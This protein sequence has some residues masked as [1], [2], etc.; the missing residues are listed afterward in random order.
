MM[1]SLLATQFGENIVSCYCELSNYNY[2]LE[3]SLFKVV[4]DTYPVQAIAPSVAYYAMRNIANA[5]NG[6]KPTYLPVNLSDNSLT[7]Y[8]FVNSL[9]E[10]MLMY[11]LRGNVNDDSVKGYVDIDL[12]VETNHATLVDTLNGREIDLMVDHGKIHNVL[13]SDIPLLIKY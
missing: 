11:F 13:A 9:G 12:G 4:E 5:T 1:L 6:Y 8:T 10:R 3:L 2:P 7:K